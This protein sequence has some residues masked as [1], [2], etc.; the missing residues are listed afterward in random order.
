MRIKLLAVFL[1]LHYTASVAQE[2]IVYRWVDNNNVVHY[3]HEHPADK[4]FA[5]VKV[6]VAYSP[7]SSPKQVKTEQVDEKKIDISHM[8]ED[9]VKKNCESA[10]TNLTILNSFEK[11]LIKDADGNDKTLTDEEKLVQIE[12]SKEY[13]GIYCES[14]NGP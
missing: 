9:V 13:V 6:H 14:G 5:E 8:D 4:D 12:Q 7:P 2:T 1:V 3:S 11:I 10:K